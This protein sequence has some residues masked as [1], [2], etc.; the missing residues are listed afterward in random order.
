MLPAT[1]K[2][3]ATFNAPVVVLVLAVASFRLVAPLT[4]NVPPKVSDVFHDGT[5][6]SLVNILFAIPIVNCVK[7]SFEPEYIKSPLL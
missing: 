6:P 5:R 4:V 2:P 3:P 7:L 1:P